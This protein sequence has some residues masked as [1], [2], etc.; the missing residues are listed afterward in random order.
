ME[1]TAPRAGSRAVAVTGGASGIGLATAAVLLEKGYAPVLL[2][3]AAP[4][5]AE[6]AA[7]LGLPEGRALVCDVTDEASV[8]AALEQVRAVMPLAGLVNSAGI[9]GDIPSLDMPA[10]AFRRI[11]E[12]NLTGSFL[13]A[14]AAAR[15]WRARGEPGAI[16]NISS[17]SGM[18]GNKG[19]SAYGASKGG[20]NTLTMVMANELGPSGIRVNAVA[21]GPIDTPLARRLHT[22]D[23]RAQWR[24]RVPLR[25]YGTPQEVGRA[26]AFLV[27]DEASY[28][29]GHVLVVDGGFLT[30]GLAS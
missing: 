16:V 26:A 11:V 4:A 20:V 18:T 15:I 30:A 5:L 27:G 21:P 29:T 2:D 12:V 22:E 6:A 19:R 17:V 10:D 25:R 9:A 13:A 28:I 1:R 24:A 14:R 7:G 8:A 3:L 23:V